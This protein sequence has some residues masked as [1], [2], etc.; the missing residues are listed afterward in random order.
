MEGDVIGIVNAVFPFLI[1]G[2][3]F[4]FMLY[5]PQQKEQKA[6][7]QL[8]D[9]LKKGDKIITIGGLY[10]TIT[11]ITE[12]NITLKIAPEVEVKMLRNAVSCLEDSPA[13]K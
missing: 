10:G 11:G 3:V 8:L 4:Y 1:M 13:K 7:R 5:R 6:R 2:G 9:G 12:K